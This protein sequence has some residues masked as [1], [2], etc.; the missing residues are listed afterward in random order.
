VSAGSSLRARASRGA[1]PGE[2]LASAQLEPEHLEGLARLQAVCEQGAGGRLKLEWASLKTRSGGLT[3]DFVWLLDGEVVGFA[4]IYQWRSIELEICGMVHPACRQRGIGRALYDAVETEV[5]ERAPASALLIVDRAFPEGERF[6]LALGGKLDHSEHR[7]QQRREP[8]ASPAGAVR[9]RRSERGDAE[10]VAHCLAAAFDEEVLRADVTDDSW[11]RRH[12]DGTRV[13]E[14]RD[15][16]EPVG[17][18]RVEQ[19]GG[20]ASIYGFAVL[21]EQQRRGYGGDALLQVTRDLHRSGVGTVSLEVLSTNDSALSLYERCGFDRVG[22][23]DY[24]SMPIACI[25]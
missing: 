24:Y 3:S 25:G 22:T 12:I 9:V 1:P 16:G 4:G 11:V 8:D 7:M 13:I 6:A 18:L 23:E 17:V 2:L 20:T 19:D 14:Q 15:S 10:F 21:P 5:A